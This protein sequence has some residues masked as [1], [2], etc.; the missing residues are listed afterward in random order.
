YFYRG[1][2]PLV[3]SE[4]GGFGF[5]EY[6][7]PEDKD[8][9]AE[10]IR[11]FKRELRGR[12]LAGDVYTQATDIEDERNGLIDPETGELS[13]PPDLLASGPSEEYDE[14]EAAD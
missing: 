13:V 4:W 8:E 14:A 1:Q 12:P 6:G 7:G 3:E 5:P 10:R 2:V 11:L 9:R